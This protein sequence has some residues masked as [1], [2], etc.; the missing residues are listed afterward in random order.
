MIPL[1][2]KCFILIATTF[3][4]FSYGQIPPTRQDPQVGQVDPRTYI[5]SRPSD[6]DLPTMSN[7]DTM[8][9]N[10]DSGMLK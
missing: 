6:I 2:K 7:F 8:P 1:F 9:S 3:L 5:Q 10:L 4:L